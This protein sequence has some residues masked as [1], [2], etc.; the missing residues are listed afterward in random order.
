MIPST[1]IKGVE[2]PAIEP[3][4]LMVIVGAAPASP[5]VACM[6]TPDT[7]PINASSTLD[8]AIWSRSSLVTLDIAPVK[9][10]FF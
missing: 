1:T 3:T 6:F 4:P 2:S 5:S 9:C 8:T 7:C 10:D